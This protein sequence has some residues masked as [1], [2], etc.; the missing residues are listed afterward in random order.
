MASSDPVAGSYTGKKWGIDDGD[1]VTTSGSSNGFF[2]LKESD[3][4]AALAN[5]TALLDIFIDACCVVRSRG[6]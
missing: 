6:L 2:R 3:D 1:A 4:T 5:A